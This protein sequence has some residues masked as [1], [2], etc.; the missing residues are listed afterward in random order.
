MDPLLCFEHLVIQSFQD[1]DYCR[2]VKISATRCHHGIKKL[3]I[4]CCAGQD[5]LIIVAV[6][7]TIFKSLACKLDLTQVRGC[8]PEVSAA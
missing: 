2:I 3:R 4:D 6:S 7:I 5:Y 1:L 8:L